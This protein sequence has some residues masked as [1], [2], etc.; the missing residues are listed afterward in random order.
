MGYHCFK[1]GLHLPIRIISC[2]NYQLPGLRQFCHHWLPKRHF[3]RP[4]NRIPHHSGCLGVGCRFMVWQYSYHTDLQLLLLFLGSGIMALAGHCTVCDSEWHCC[5][6]SD[7]RAPRI[8]KS[9]D[10]FKGTGR[11]Y[12]PEFSPLEWNA[13]AYVS[14]GALGS[15]P[16]LLPDF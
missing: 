3:S 16:G 15:L 6:W 9:R 10:Q 4:G 11:Q 5:L 8:S 7:G 1:N 2:W 13:G 14:S 12:G